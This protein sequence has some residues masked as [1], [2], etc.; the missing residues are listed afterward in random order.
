[1]YTGIC[2][3]QGLGT[4]YLEMMGNQMDKDMKHEMETEIT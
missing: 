3:V 4:E 2:R 1:M